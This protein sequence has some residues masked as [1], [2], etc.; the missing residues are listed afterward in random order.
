MKTHRR[1][2]LAFAAATSTLWLAS[3]A[4]APLD[5]TAV[6][7][8]ARAAMS[9]DSVKTLR[10]TSSGTGAVHGQAYLPDTK[11]PIVN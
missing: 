7:S 11:W 4:T 9:A 2:L 6:I 5:A 10:F 8:K 1:T 3:C